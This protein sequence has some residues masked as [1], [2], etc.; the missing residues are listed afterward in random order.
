[1]KGQGAVHIKT[2]YQNS[3]QKLIMNKTLFS[4]IKYRHGGRNCYLKSI[5]ANKTPLENE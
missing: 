3:V 4:K 5:K 1:M 2:A